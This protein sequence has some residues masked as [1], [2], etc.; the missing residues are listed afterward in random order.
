MSASEARALDVSNRFEARWA[1]PWWDV[2]SFQ[3]QDHYKKNLSS[4]K[5]FVDEVENKWL[6]MFKEKGW[7]K[8]GDTLQDDRAATFRKALADHEDFLTRVNALGDYLARP[9]SRED[10][11]EKYLPLMKEGGEIMERMFG[12]ARNL[13][14]SMVILAAN[15]DIKQTIK[16][17]DLEH[18]QPDPEFELYKKMTQEALKVPEPIRREQEAKGMQLNRQIK[19]SR[20]KESE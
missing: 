6:P 18:K 12:A 5:A 15:S 4:S 14:H 2:Q 16:D 19:R 13:K 3:D 11:I 10:K 17:V 7:I 8:P 1:H 20:S 9:V